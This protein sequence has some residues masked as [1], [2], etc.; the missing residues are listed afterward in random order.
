MTANKTRKFDGEKYTLYGEFDTKWK[1]ENAADRMS[2]TH[3]FFRIIKVV[4]RAPPQG[5]IFFRLY[6]RR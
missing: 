4:S 6:Y 2:G 3:R 5:D 1:A